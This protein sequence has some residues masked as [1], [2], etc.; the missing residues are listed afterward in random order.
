ME[1]L[2]KFDVAEYIDTDELQTLYLDEVTNENDPAALIKAMDTVA[3]SKG[4][5]KTAKDAG[6]SR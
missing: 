1:K 2:T 4:M 3:R 5:T 6:I